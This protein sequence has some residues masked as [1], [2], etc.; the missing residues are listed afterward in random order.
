[1]FVN[2]FETRDRPP[3]DCPASWS[4]SIRATDQ[5]APMKNDG[6]SRRGALVELS[7]L[8]LVVYG[9]FLLAYLFTRSA[10]VSFSW[11]EAYTYLHHVQHG[12]LWPERFDEMG[13]NLHLLNVW[14]MWIADNLLG[15]H[16][17]MLRLPNV[18]AGALYLGLSFLLVR[19]VRP[20]PVAL[21]LYV[22][23][24]A[25]PYMLD[26]FSL[27]RGYGVGI[28]FML[29]SLVHMRKYATTPSIRAGVLAMVGAG[30]ASLSN[31]I[32]LNFLFAAL[33][34]MAV[35]LLC[36]PV[37]GKAKW[38]KTALILLTPVPLIG[39]TAFLAYQLNAG[40][41]LYFGSADLPEAIRSVAI[42]VFYHLPDYAEP[43]VLFKWA[44]GVT[45]AV[46][47]AI[48]LIGLVRGVRA[49]WYPM[50]PGMLVLTFWSIGMSVEHAL[51]GTPWPHARTGIWVIPSAGFFFVTAWLNP[52]PGV[53][54]LK[55]A[56]CI[57]AIP[58]FQLQSRA[59]NLTY[60]IEWKASGEVR[61]MVERLRSTAGSN[62]P[63][64][65]AITVCSGFESRMP[66]FYYRSLYRMHGLSITLLDPEGAIPRSDF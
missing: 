15:S 11:D 57:L 32:F 35:L 27:A 62:R 42:K 28:A 38:K 31:L 44:L 37:Q 1:M 41:S 30:L 56:A 49:V 26:M 19:S 34:T 14:L 47:A 2:G 60:C 50:F 23:L 54:V 5:V 3:V 48:F 12:I 43:V 16:E 53:R 59:L 66:L 8:P 18:L 55:W 13:A 25:H 51:F 64:G 58:I 17:W 10:S 9:L 52:F 61:N 20:W 40:G 39:A 36:E 21:A 6:M 33:A 29:L 46:P 63:G 65:D 24:T 45:L 22:L 4:A 7:D